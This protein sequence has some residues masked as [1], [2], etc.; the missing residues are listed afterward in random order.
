[1]IKTN[2]FPDRPAYIMMVP[3]QEILSEVLK[4]STHSQTVQNEYKKLIDNF[5]GEFETLQ[6]IPL[7][8]IT[9]ISGP[10]VADGVGK[11]RNGEITI[12]PG[13]DGVFGVVKIW[14][15][16][17]KEEEKKKEQLSLF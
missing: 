1:M 12:D 11:V 5:G 10:M 17:K 13:Y 16:E 4:S 15:E 2:I 9:R 3:L 7:E 14:G 8:D 6:S